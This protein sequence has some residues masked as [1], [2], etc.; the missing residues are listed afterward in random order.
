[1]LIHPWAGPTLMAL[2]PDLGRW[3]TEV[4]EWVIDAHSSE[5]YA[6]RDCMLA[7][8]SVRLSMPINQIDL[9]TTA[10]HSTSGVNES[11]ARVYV[12]ETLPRELWKRSPIRYGD[13]DGR[14]AVR[15][16]ESGEWA[17][18]WNSGQFTLSIMN[19][20]KCVVVY[21]KQGAFPISE[22]G[23]PLRTP[24]HWLAS[25]MNT[26]FVHAAAVDW[27]GRAVVLGGPSGAGKSTFSLN[28]LNA[29]LGI[30]G[31][32]YVVVDHFD[33]RPSVYSSYRT[34][35]FK[36]SQRLPNRERGI[37]LHNG[38][39]ALLMQPNHI[40]RKSSIFAVAL[41]DQHGPALPEEVDRANAARVLATSTIL[42][43]PL[44][45]RL[46]LAE[47]ASIATAVP[48]YRVGWTLNPKTTRRAIEIMVGI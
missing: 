12:S 5:A 46:I 42:Q 27:G 17:V 30:L 1:M 11:A 15:G 35:K 2:Q 14:G 18:A 32:D 41:I 47:T 24:A 10:L 37:D 8:V 3:V 36:V 25:E 33:T 45:A 22:V 20:E 7:N 21:I 6:S 43:V 29:G 4:F 23:G 34:I 19:R 9:F 16:S 48:C 38:K 13:I 28:A 39:R 31:D 44:Y 40:I 26:A